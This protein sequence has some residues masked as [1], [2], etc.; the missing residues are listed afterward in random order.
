MRRDTTRHQAPFLIL[1]ALATLAGCGDSGGG[2]DGGGGGTVPPPTRTPVGTTTGSPTSQ[3]IGPAGGT[4]TA[5]GGAVSLTVP[6][7][8]L[9]ANTDIFWKIDAVG[10]GGKTSG[11]ILR[12]HTAALP[13]KATLPS[14]AN[15]ATGVDPA[16]ELSWTA[17]TNATSH[18]VYF[19]T[20]QSAVQN[21]PWH[22]A[23]A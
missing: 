8:A 22:K 12:F 7:G 23:S 5:A 2:P 3:N 6:A 10:P 9:A 19:G 18:D 20:N 14:P 21:A 16:A 1:L 4:L 15:G 13:T 11:P 17:G